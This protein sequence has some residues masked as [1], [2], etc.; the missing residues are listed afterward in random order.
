MLACK[1]KLFR[2]LLLFSF[3]F[4]VFSFLCNQI[5]CAEVK[6]ANSK[7]IQHAKQVNVQQKKII[8]SLK[9]IE[10]CVDANHDSIK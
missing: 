6:V 4:L 2:K 9:K 8:S 5:I 1:N 10:D 7:T 3:V